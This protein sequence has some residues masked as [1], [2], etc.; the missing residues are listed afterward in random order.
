M[1]IK[2]AR[3]GRRTQ[4]EEAHLHDETCRTV[5]VVFVYESKCVK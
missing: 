5:I 4:E 3:M 2:R 1:G